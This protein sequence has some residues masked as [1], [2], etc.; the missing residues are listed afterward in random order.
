M[1][2]DDPLV[3]TGFDLTACQERRYTVWVGG[4]LCYPSGPSVLLTLGGPDE[5]E[6]LVELQLP[7][8]EAEELLWQIK[9]RIETWFSADT[10]ATIQGGK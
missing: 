2:R 6:P 8:A 4:Q 1:K 10:L 3:L 5:G 7:R 9:N